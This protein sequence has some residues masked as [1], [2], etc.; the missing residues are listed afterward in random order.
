MKKLLP[1]LFLTIVLGSCKKGSDD[2]SPAP[3]VTSPSRQLL[4]GRWN[5]VSAEA[6]IPQLAGPPITTL[7]TFPS[8]NQYDVF[9]ATTVESFIGSVSQRISTYSL[10]GSAYTI[11]EN[12]ITTIY[13]L[14]ELT[15]TKLVTSYSYPIR[16]MAGPGTAVVTNTYTR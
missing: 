9:T 2:P 3:V 4:L 13:D 5:Q 14:K 11:T 12:G 6:T 1:F 10:S 8:G 15:T 16:T 7:V